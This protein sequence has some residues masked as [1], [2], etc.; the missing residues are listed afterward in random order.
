MSSA[1]WRRCGVGQGQ[2]EALRPR[3][4]FAAC[5]RHASTGRWTGEPGP[6]VAAPPALACRWPAPAPL[7]SPT[8]E[9]PMPPGAGLTPT[10]NRRDHR[11]R[12]QEP[13]CPGL[14]PHS[15][16]RGSLCR[17]G[18]PFVAVPEAGLRQR[19]RQAQL[20]AGKRGRRRALRALFLHR[21]AGAHAAARQRLSHRGGH[22]RRRWWRRTT[23]TRWTS[24]P[25]TRSA[26]RWRCARGCR[27]FAAG[28]PATSAT[29]R[30]A[31]SSRSWRNTWKSG[32]I[33]T[34]DIL[35]L[36][37]EELA[38]IDNLSGRLY[39]IVYA[40][41][42]E[43]EAFSKAKRRLARPWATSCTTASPRRR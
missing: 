39:L 14:Q 11:T 8:R 25:S 28:W 35:L 36:Q 38:V 27:A 1:R 34:P 12:I 5:S 16:D 22:R 29:T 13:E 31:T 19:R 26:S 18:N 33:D 2:P 6:G 10:R 30:C 20:P 24:S 7:G 15:A 32:G 23:A 9:G 37:C 3:L 4:D 17:P 40:D 42:G 21:P 43:P 41:P